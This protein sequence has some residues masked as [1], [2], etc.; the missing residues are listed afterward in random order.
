M[1]TR[2]TKANEL[3][4]LLQRGPSLAGATS[5]RADDAALER[6]VRLWL[7][8][9]VAPLACDLVPELQRDAKASQIARLRAL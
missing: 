5:N 9:W 3:R 4:A 6:R 7:D 2:R 1:R 8:T